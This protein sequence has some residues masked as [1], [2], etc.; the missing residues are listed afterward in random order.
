MAS[1]MT[2]NNINLDEINKDNPFSTPENYF[3]SFSIRMSDKISETKRTKAP[4]FAWMRPGYAIIFAFIGIAIIMTGVFVLNSKNAPLSS[5]EMV[6][7]Y[8][9]SA[10]QELSDEQLAQM[11]AEK[12][13]HQDTTSAYQ[14]D[15]IDYLSKENIEIN[16]IIEAQ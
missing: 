2:R 13:M 4:A 5:Q 14:K 16:T 7:V 3:E 15:V 6:E 11:I 10:I 1:K 9:Y 8:K 12:Q